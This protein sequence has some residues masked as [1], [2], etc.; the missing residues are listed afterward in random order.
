MNS[1]QTPLPVPQ[2]KKKK[3]KRTIGQDIA[4]RW[5]RSRNTGNAVNT[6]ILEFRPVTTGR[7][8]LTAAVGKKV[9]GDK[10]RLQEVHFPQ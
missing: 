2:M 7:Y 3:E 5:Q 8:R 4:W 10:I 9:P 1:F 6:L